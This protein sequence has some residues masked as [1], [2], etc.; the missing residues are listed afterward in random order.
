M[1]ASDYFNREGS[2]ESKYPRKILQFKYEN[3][4]HRTISRG[5]F[6]SWREYFITSK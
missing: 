4:T 6:I 5:V 1:A 3:T 2:Q